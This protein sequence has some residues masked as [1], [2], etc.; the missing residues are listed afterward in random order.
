MVIGPPPL[1][2]D[3]LDEA[4]FAL[5]IR[6]SSKVQSVRG[7]PEFPCLV[8]HSA[9]ALSVDAVS[10]PGRIFKTPAFNRPSLVLLER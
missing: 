8:N 3:D 1:D 7:I 10:I 9:D 2:T 5:A 6:N 4:K